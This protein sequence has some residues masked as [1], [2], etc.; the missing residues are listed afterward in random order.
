MLMP[1]TKDELFEYFDQ[2]GIETITYE[3]EALHTVE[4][5]QALRGQIPGGHTKNLFLKSK[6]QDLWLVVAL[7][8]T[9]VDLKTLHKVL[10]TGRFS[11]GRPE[12]LFETLGVRPG[13]V[14]PFSLINDTKL[15]VQVVLDKGMMAY[16]LL[17]FH[18]LENRYTT[19]ISRDNLVKFIEATGHQP[20]F[21][22]LEDLNQ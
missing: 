3:H 15:K 20:L 12:L 5:S 7:E 2:L 9:Q 19:T 17:N 16:E 21:L 13:S 22:D 6:K 11:F 1:T 10:E 4:A 8:T 14:T 18:P